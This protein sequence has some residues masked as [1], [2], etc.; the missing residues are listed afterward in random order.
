MSIHNNGDVSQR[1]F[2]PQAFNIKVTGGD[3]GAKVPAGK[4]G[5]QLYKST[6]ELLQW[7]LYWHTAGATIADAPGPQ[8]ASVASASNARRS[9]ARDFSS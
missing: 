4:K 1:Q 8:L 7:D 5:T 6:D 3:D 2:W 9:H